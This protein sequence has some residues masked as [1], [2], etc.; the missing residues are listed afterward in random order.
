MA[1]VL[2]VLACPFDPI[3]SRFDRSISRVHFRP[4]GKVSPSVISGLGRV[5]PSYVALAAA[6]VA[7]IDAVA[8]MA[9]NSL[10][11]RTHRSSARRHW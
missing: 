5:N 4:V 9:Q 7:Q 6:N 3:E 10:N 2:L 8:H 1:R 11:D